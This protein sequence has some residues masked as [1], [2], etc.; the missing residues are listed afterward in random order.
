MN[1]R[2]SCL[3]SDWLR[4][5]GGQELMD[6]GHDGVVV[7]QQDQF[8]AAGVKSDRASN[9]G[10]ESSKNLHRGKIDPDDPNALKITSP[11]RG[12]ILKQA[13]PHGL[14]GA[15]IGRGDGDPDP[16]ATFVGEV[17]DDG[18]ARDGRRGQC[19]TLRGKN[20]TLALD[21]QGGGDNDRETEQRR[22]RHCRQGGAR[23]VPGSAL[24]ARHSG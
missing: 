18:L 11:D 10:T 24:G 16:A 8:A 13:E 4:R 23:G 20:V 9:R 19:R 3:K 5:I 1:V 12:G 17:L 2:G 22:V 7:T 15:G 21:G 14:N 6:G